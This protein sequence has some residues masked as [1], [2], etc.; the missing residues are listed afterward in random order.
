MLLMGFIKIK[1]HVLIN[2]MFQCRVVASSEE[3]INSYGYILEVR[4]DIGDRLSVCFCQGTKHMFAK[5][6]HLCPSNRIN[7]IVIVV[8]T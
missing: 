5:Y 2:M 7:G 1:Q 3:G 4:A 8:E 6:T